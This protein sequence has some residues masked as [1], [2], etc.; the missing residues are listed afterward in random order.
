M[1]NSIFII[2]LL[3]IVAVSCEDKE[4]IFVGSAWYVNDTGETLLLKTHEK[5]P[6][7]D[8]YYVLFER[9]IEDGDSLEISLTNEFGLVIFSGKG[10]SLTL[11]TPNL[12]CRAYSRQ[13]TRSIYLSC[14]GE[15]PFRGDDYSVVSI[16]ENNG[17]RFTLM[18]LVI[19]DRTF[20][21]GGPCP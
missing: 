15:G 20:S 17:K 8:G 1:K 18:R 13:Y 9:T 11:E 5:E 6:F 7:I 19:N 3:I 10:D 2:G 12:G 21:Q 16:S 14:C 4:L